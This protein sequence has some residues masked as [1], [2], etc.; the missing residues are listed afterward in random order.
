MPPLWPAR[1]DYEDGDVVLPGYEVKTHP[2]RSLLTGG[3]ITLLV[4]YGAS[5][6]FGGFLVLAGGRNER[7]EFGPLLIPVLGPFVAMGMWETTHEEGA[8]IMLANGFAQV[9]G[10][11]MIVSSILLPEKTLDRMA[12]LPG[13]PEVFVGAGTAT[14]RMRF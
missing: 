3:L 11:A 6:L 5:A 9:A 12:T 14:L 4:P 7:Q 13:K 2:D 8:F 10:A 1:I